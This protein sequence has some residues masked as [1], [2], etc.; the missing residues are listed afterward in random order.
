MQTY[1]DL[2]IIV[3]DQTPR[4]PPEVAAYLAQWSRP[5]FIYRTLANAGLT[6]ARNDG[7]RIATGELVI[8]IDDDVAIVPDFVARHVEAHQRWEQAAASDKTKAP[9]GGISGVNL[10]PRTPTWEAVRARQ[11]VHHGKHASRWG[12]VWEAEWLTGCNMSFRREVLLRAGGF[13][14]RLTGGA[15]GEDVDISLSVRGLGYRLVMERGLGLWHHQAQE[16][17]GEHRAADAERI[18]RERITA[19]LYLIRKHWRTFGHREALWRLWHQYRMYAGSLA[20]WR[21]GGMGLVVRR[22]REFWRAWLQATPT[23]DR[24]Q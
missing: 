24:K 5:R 13:D 14:E 20:L 8:F 4:N 18:Q 22:H 12:E 17:G 2:D 11:A 1:H 6:A 15:W 10:S 3:V 7:L 9:V 21:Q 23:L 19:W 16:G